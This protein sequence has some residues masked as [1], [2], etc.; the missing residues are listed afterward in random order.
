MTYE[1]YSLVG[2][3]EKNIN[4]F[5]FPNKDFNEALVFKVKNIL[6]VFVTLV[7]F[8][9]IEKDGSHLHWEW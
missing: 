4:I 6:Y 5:Q 9:N 8:L 3:T 7:F 2:E 1:T